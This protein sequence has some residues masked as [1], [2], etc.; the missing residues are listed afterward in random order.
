MTKGGPQQKPGIARNYDALIPFRSQMTCSPFAVVQ[1]ETKPSCKHKGFSHYCYV[2][3]C[4]ASAVQGPSPG[5]MGNHLNGRLEHGCVVLSSVIVYCSRSQSQGCQ[6]SHRAAAV[7][8]RSLRYYSYIHTSSFSLGWH[9]VLGCHRAC[10][11]VV[12]HCLHPGHCY[13]SCGSAVDGIQ[14]NGC[15]G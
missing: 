5:A 2:A 12:F 9:E 6:V 8:H 11:E 7:Y 4:H 10:N 13:I 14:P 15:M 1:E 3:A